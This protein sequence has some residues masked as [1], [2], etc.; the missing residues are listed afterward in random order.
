MKLKYQIA[1]LGT[2]VLLLVGVLLLRRWSPRFVKD[3]FTADTDPTNLAIFRIVFFLLLASSFSVSNIVWFSSIPAELRFPPQGLAWLTQILPINPTWAWIASVLLLICCITAALG[4]FTRVSTILCFVLGL[5]VLGI[6]QFYG[7]INHYHHLLWFT[8]ILAASPC[9]DVLAIDAVFSSWRRA[10][11]GAAGRPG[12]SQVYALPLRFIWLSMGVIYFSA[13]FWKVWTS[14]YKWAF[15]DNPKI[16]MYNKWLE[17]GGWRPILNIDQHPMLYQ[18]SAAATIVFEL[19]FIVII[20]FPAI[21]FLAPL[22]GLAFHNMT[23]LFMRIPFWQLQVCYVA[24]PDWDR[25]FRSLGKRLFNAEMFVVYDGNCKLCRRTIASL[26]TID[27]LHRV[28]YVNGL[29]RDELER[30]DLLWLNSEALLHDMFA[31]VG[32]SEWRG[33]EAYRVLTRRFPTLWPMLPFLYVWPIPLIAR[34]VYRRVADSRACSIVESKAPEKTIVDAS[35]R[36]RRVTVL[37][38]GLILYVAILSAVGKIQSWPIAVYP[39]FE[40][41]DPPQVSVITMIVQGRNGQIREVSPVKEQTL[42]QM[43]PERLA[44][45]LGRILATEDETLRSE[46]LRAL[47]AVWSRDDEDLKQASIVRFYRE[48]LSSLPEKQVDNPIDRKLLYELRL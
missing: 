48:T 36:K 15:S 41:I 47:W 6:P 20:F 21:R 32:K 35:L 28:T 25:W 24:F 12:R 27:I 29:V 8:A 22:G 18:L 43:P 7:K 5:Y 40:D 2:G 13:G 45:L 11:K 26:Q 42:S 23:N 44:A 4:L 37:V 3:F 39:T 17:L 19:S 31:V 33:F 46:R 1:I 14:G 16:M 34:R 38:G 10:D 9:A 30:R